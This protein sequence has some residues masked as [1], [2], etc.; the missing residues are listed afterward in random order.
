MNSGQSASNLSKSPLNSAFVRSGPNQ[1][2]GLSDLASLI[3]SGLRTMNPQILPEGKSPNTL[4]TTSALRKRNEDGD[5]ERELPATRTQKE[6]ESD[7]N[8]RTTM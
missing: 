7:T 2:L 5:R 4:V 8:V 1:G 6:Q 3:Q